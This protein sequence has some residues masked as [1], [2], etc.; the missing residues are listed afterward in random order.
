MVGTMLVHQPFLMGGIE[1]VEKA[2]T[3]A[4][5]AAGTFFFPFLISIVYLL[6]GSFFSFD[7]VA[8]TIRNTTTNNPL[9]PGGGSR[10][11]YDLVSLVQEY[12]HDDDEIEGHEM[13]EFS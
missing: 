8:S 3:S 12:H 6:A 4:F 5:G 1:D 13:G 7:S 10:G 9:S 11:A 2:K